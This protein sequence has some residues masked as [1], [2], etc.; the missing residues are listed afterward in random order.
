MSTTTCQHSFR[1][2]EV[3]CLTCPAH[4]VECDCSQ[5][6][7]AEQEPD[8]SQ[9]FTW[10]ARVESYGRGSTCRIRE[11]EFGPVRWDGTRDAVELRE[12][13]GTGALRKGYDRFNRWRNPGP[14]A[15]INIQSADAQECREAAQT[16]IE[17]AQMIEEATR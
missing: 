5:C 10:W 9:P 12:Y 4:R 14:H 1:P 17:A 16:L 11:L 13:L 3:R 7:P 6:E 15:S 8:L 2:G